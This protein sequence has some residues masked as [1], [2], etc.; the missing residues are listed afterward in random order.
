VATI[1]CQPHTLTAGFSWYFLQLL[2]PGLNWLPTIKLQ[3]HS[4]VKIQILLRRTFSRPV[5]LGVRPPAGAKN[6]IF[7]TVKTVAGL[8]T[9]GTLS[10]KRRGLWLTI[11]AGPRLRSH[12][13]VRVPRDSRPYFTVS[14]SGLPHLEG[15]VPVFKS[16]RNRVAYL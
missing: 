6:Q 8:L 4:K 5:C 15:Q 1:S 3:L 11:A 16:T 13:R 7:I 2:A 10:D 9:W 12:S 14:D